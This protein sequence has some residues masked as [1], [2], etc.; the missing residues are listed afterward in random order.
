M[1]QTSG[2]HAVSSHTGL[3][4]TWLSEMDRLIHHHRSSTVVASE[5]VMSRKKEQTIKCFDNTDHLEEYMQSFRE[6]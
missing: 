5:K 4:W 1:G 3:I 6:G 2:D